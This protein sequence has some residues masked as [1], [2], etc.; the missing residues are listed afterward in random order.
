MGGIDKLKFTKVYF[1]GLLGQ[2]FTAVSNSY[3]VPVAVNVQ[4]GTSL[5]GGGDLN[6]RV[7][8]LRVTRVAAFPDILFSA[9]DL[10]DGGVARTF[11]V[12]TRS[13]QLQVN[14]GP[15]IMDNS[16]SISFNKIG[17]YVVNLLTPTTPF[18]SEANALQR[19]RF[20]AFDGSTNPP[21]IFPSGASIKELERIY[22]GGN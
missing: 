13:T 21:V 5:D 19:L 6:L 10:L 8:Q 14:N 7:E 22:F 2:T 1:D 12:Y 9:G 16:I 11:P 18:V 17:P 15:G 4:S 3:T 20:G